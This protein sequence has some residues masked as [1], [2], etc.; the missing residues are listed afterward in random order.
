[1]FIVYWIYLYIK[2]Y[3]RYKFSEGDVINYMID[4]A[5]EVRIFEE[6]VVI[7]VELFLFGYVGLVL[8]GFLR[9]F[10]FDR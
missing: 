2:F 9:L 4:V 5:N 3:S 7:V 10:C 8:V 1:M 6:D